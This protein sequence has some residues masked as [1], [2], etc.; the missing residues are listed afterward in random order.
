[1]LLLL[2]ACAAPE[3]PPAEIVR[4][5]HAGAVCPDP[6]T[7]PATPPTTIVLVTIDSVN[8]DFLGY[9]EDTWDTTPNIDR[10]F[11]EGV[12]LENVLVTRGLS[13]PSLASILTGA[14]PR[15]HGVRI[16]EEVTPSGVAPTLVTR[17]REAGWRTL[18]YTTN[19]CQIVSGDGADDYLCL[20]NPTR[21]DL[22]QADADGLVTSAFE[23]GIAASAGPVFAWIHLMDPHDPFHVREPWYT[24]FHPEAY[25]GPL[26]DPSPADIEAYTMGESVMT[27]EDRSHLDAMYASQLAG[28]DAQVG[29]IL[30]ALD[31]TG[32]SDAIVAFGVDHGEELARRTTYFYHGCSVYDLV[33][34]A[35]YAIRAPGRIPA[36]EVLSGWVSAADVAPTLAELGGLTWSGAADGRSLVD[37]IETCV[38]PNL[39]VYFERGELAAGVIDQGSQFILDPKLGDRTCS[40]QDSA[41]DYPGELR[42]FYDLDT[43]PDQVENLYPDG[44]VYEA[45]LCDWVLSAPWTS[46]GSDASNPLVGVCGRSAGR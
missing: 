16:N 25:S 24:T 36:G 34:G 20:D 7:P 18:V 3:P 14:Y 10:L 27:E 17:F 42:A 35:S 46:D 28:A 37:T 13:A 39:P 40:Y 26:L 38:E 43:D 31:A 22:D 45:E 8:R 1:M 19:V 30:A 29:R 32:R 11:A 15:T 4:E 12:V 21:P 6:V 33:T 41:Y 2:L 23:A 9:Y 5:E 44:G